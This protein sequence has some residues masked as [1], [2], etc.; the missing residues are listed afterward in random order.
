MSWERMKDIQQKGILGG[1]L[2][3]RLAKTEEALALVNREKLNIFQPMTL[4]RLGG[5]RNCHF[6]NGC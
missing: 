2:H 4:E 6:L 3:E 5:R 1:I